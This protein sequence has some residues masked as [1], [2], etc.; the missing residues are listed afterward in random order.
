MM[1]QTY[2]TI[3]VA[4]YLLELGIILL[5]KKQTN[6]TT[7]VHTIIKNLKPHHLAIYSTFY[8]GLLLIA[9][10]LPFFYSVIIGLQIISIVFDLLILNK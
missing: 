7:H 3:S 5:I 8:C 4:L 10:Y 2:L 6:K 1:I 9:F